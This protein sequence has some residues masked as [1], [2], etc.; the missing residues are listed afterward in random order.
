MGEARPAWGV[1]RLLGP[2]CVAGSEALSGVG[3]VGEWAC[4]GKLYPPTPIPPPEDLWDTVTAIVPGS[5]DLP[6]PVTVLF[7][8]RLR[9]TCLLV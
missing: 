8:S 5:N 9:Y 2:N 7:C 4:S 6:I 1:A 3:G